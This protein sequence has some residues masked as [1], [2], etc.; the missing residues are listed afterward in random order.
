MP[1]VDLRNVLAL[2]ASAALLGSCDLFAGS[3]GAAP[4]IDPHL[5]QNA[6]V[7]ISSITATFAA[8]VTTY[9]VSISD[10]PGQSGY[11]GTAT[12]KWTISATCGTFTPTAG[13][14]SHSSATWAHPDKDSGGD[15]PTEPKHPGVISVEVRFPPN[16]WTCRAT[17]TEGSVQ[18]KGPPPGLCG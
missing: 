12:Y 17:Y 9:T 16:P 14:G 3:D 18:G 10:A 6:P 15:C 13:V 5:Y 7:A 11:A 2:L 4:S 1:K 8:P